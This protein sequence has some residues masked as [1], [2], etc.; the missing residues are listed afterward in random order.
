MCGRFARGELTWAQLQDWLQLGSGPGADG[1]SSRETEI[2][3]RYNLAPTMTT[4]IVRLV[5]G[6]RHGENARWG[7]I[8]HW[9]TKPLSQM[10]LSTFNARSEEVAKKPTFKAALKNRCLV[11]AVGYYE[12][13][14]PKGRKQPHFISVERNAPGFCF[15]GLWSHAR[16]PDFEGVTFTLLTAAPEPQIAHIHNRMPVILDEAGYD[17]WLS[18]EDNI[19]SMRRIAGERLRHHAVGQAVGAVRNEGAEL[20]KPI[21]G[22]ASAQD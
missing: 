16:L 7:L 5:D 11:P 19:A 18:G 20:I 8:P 12:W 21:E 2:N 15:A 1:P 13:T 17:G 4:P 6:K 22:A 3:P 10:K 9:F 14:G